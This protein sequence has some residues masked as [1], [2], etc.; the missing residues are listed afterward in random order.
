MMDPAVKTA[1][2]FCVL[3]VASARPSCSAVIP[4]RRRRPPR[5]R[6]SSFSSAIRPSRPPLICRPRGWDAP[7]PLSEQPTAPVRERPRSSRPRTGVNRR[8]YWQTATRNPIAPP[9]RW[10][11]SMDMLLPAA[12]PADEA[13]HSHTI[14]DGDTLAAL[15]QRYLGS[16]ARALE[17]Y[18]ANRNVL[19]DPR[20]LPIGAELKIP[21]RGSLPARA[22]APPLDNLPSA[23]LAPCPLVLP[24]LRHVTEELG[25]ERL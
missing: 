12:A 16:A 19:S 20:L 4:P 23:S 10:G 14:V 15:A 17:I 25:I 21:P 6:P 5:H 8:P 3:L 22:A 13:I 9:A 7:D 1:M 24:K 18:E 2:T 11:M